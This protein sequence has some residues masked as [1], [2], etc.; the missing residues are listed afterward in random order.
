[1][2]AIPIRQKTL[3]KRKQ[4]APRVFAGI[5]RDEQ[6]VIARK[7][8]QSFSWPKLRVQD[9][10][11]GQKTGHR[12]V[13]RGQDS[14]EEHPWLASLQKERIRLALGSPACD[15]ENAKRLEPP[16]KRRKLFLAFLAIP[17]H[18]P[19]LRVR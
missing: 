11:V 5:Q 1:L 16:P 15:I 8:G 14:I 12:G 19:S 2:G 18:L 17:S 4:R 6:P 7:Q 13:L 3:R 10:V 9:N